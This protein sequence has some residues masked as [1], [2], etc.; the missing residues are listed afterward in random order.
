M[1]KND[2]FPPGW[3]SSY[4]AKLPFQFLQ[5]IP[6]FILAF[7]GLINGLHAQSLT[8]NSSGTFIVPPG[9]TSITVQAWGAGG[10]GASGGTGNRAGG[11]GGAFA[12]KIIA[13][14]PGTS[15]TVTVGSG[16]APG[17]TGG[18]SS[19]GAE[20]IAVGGSSGSGLTGGT[21]GL[22]SNCTP[23]V[24]AFSGGNGGG[25]S[26]TSGLLNIDGGGGGGGAAT[27]SA[28]GRS[29]ANG[30]N[31][32]SG[33]GGLAGG[34]VG[35]GGGAGGAGDGGNGGFGTFSTGQT[36]FA[37]GG[38][39]GGRSEHL[40]STAGSG[41]SGR[42]S[43]SWSCGLTVSNFSVA[44]TEPMCKNGPATVTL[45][46]NTVPDGNY[47]VV[48]SISGANTSGNNNTSVTFAAGT[49]S[50]NT[51]NLNNGGNT[52]ITVDLLDCAIPS[53]N[54]DNFVVDGGPPQPGSITGGASVC[55]N[56]P[57]LVYSVADVSGATSYTWTVPTGWQI[58][59]GQGTT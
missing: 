30:S 46:S 26:S 3:Q 7:C 20:V 36:G 14:T 28:N 23:T 56:T 43:V 45:N 11:G 52:T 57:G 18:N 4:W 42:V 22:A 16:G 8:F 2:T 21:G 54:T 17:S 19:F 58:T 9:V 27:S 38:G 31:G 39:G 55:D 51:V 13:V 41:A 48:Y 12:T 25:S 1:K 32:A 24:G 15:Y 47:T 34:G 59:A 5:R 37:P 40:T 53:N 33:A 49:A 10:G 44:V 35:T 50:F 29:G 6:L